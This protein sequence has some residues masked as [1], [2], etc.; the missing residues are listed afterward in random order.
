MN[1]SRARPGE[2]DR[3]FI[4][5][6]EGLQ[7]A[8]DRAALAALRRGLGRPPG[9]AAEMHRY[10][11]PWLP[12]EESPREDEAYYLAA[13]LF[14]LYPEGSWPREEAEQGWHNLGASF[15][16]LAS[17]ADSGSVEQR[18]VALLGAHR[19]DLPEHLRHAVSLLKAHEV[20]VDWVELLADIRWW[21]HEERRV[22]RR[23][24][25]AFWGAVAADTESNADKNLA[26]QAK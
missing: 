22:Q 23:W 1:I 15:A 19:D 6:L 12:R 20:R 10:V 8:E 24:A 3:A 21:D 16:H 7:A 9:T 4:A 26:D 11:V 14:G 18:F 13:A 5:Y 2:R 25:R 17:R